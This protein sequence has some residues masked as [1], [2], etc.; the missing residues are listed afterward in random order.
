MKTYDT[1][2]DQAQ[3]G[4]PYVA[5]SDKGKAGHFE[6]YNL[7]K[8]LTIIEGQT[9]YQE[10]YTQQTNDMVVECL[11]EFDIE[12]KKHLNNNLYLL[13][14]ELKLQRKAINNIAKVLQERGML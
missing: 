10:R 9:N 8:R 2:I 7:T 12:P 1:K 5:T 6:K 3:K 11:K 4:A 13:T 14:T